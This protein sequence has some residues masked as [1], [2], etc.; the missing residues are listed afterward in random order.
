MGQ[1][2]EAIQHY[3]QALRIQPDFAEV[4]YNVGLA[5][6]KV[7]RTPEAIQHYEQALRIRPDFVQAQYALA[8]LRGTE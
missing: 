6:E 1:V 7:G 2:P 3:E 5:L 8:R 4:H